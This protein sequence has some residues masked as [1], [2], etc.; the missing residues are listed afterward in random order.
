[1]QTKRPIPSMRRSKHLACVRQAS[2]GLLGV[3]AKLCLAG[4]HKQWLGAEC[5]ELG[6]VVKQAVI[7]TPVNSPLTSCW[8]ISEIWL[9]ALWTFLLQRPRATTKLGG[10]CSVKDPV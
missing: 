5:G 4:A 6:N 3:K 7:Q 9:Q 1:M 10:L 2:P 8:V